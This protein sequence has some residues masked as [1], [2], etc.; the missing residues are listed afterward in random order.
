M[1]E[2]KG[3]RLWAENFAVRKDAPPGGWVQFLA[4]NLSRTEWFDRYNLYLRSYAWMQRRKGVI[5]R[6]K[7]C[8]LCQSDERLEVHHVTY[9]RVGA[10]RI[11]DL[12]LLCHRCHRKV[13]ERGDKWVPLTQTLRDERDRR[14][15][16]AQ[17]KAAA[18]KVTRRRPANA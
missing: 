3:W 9:Q 16:L 18:K 11:E 12:R 14:R 17:Q 4:G 2:S 6:E 7:V 8:Q 1:Y 13:E 5:N 15:H 10:E